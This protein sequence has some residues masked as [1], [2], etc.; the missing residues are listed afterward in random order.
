MQMT[1]AQQDAWEGDPNAYVADE[2]ED[3]FSVRTSGELVLEE[4]LGQADGAAGL[5]AGAVQRRL[6][7]AAAAR[8]R[9]LLHSTRGL[10]LS[11]Q[12]G[13]AC[14]LVKYNPA[15]MGA[16]WRHDPRCPQPPSVV[17]RHGQAGACYW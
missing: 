11:V 12:A 8:V 10:C 9:C 14:T 2:E 5:L 13:S 15:C 4:L 17:E 1:A 7:D 6:A 3:T 16:R